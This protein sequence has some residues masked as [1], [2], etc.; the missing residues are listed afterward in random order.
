MPWPAFLHPRHWPRNGLTAAVIVAVVLG[1]PIATARLYA[2]LPVRWLAV[3]YVEF[4]RGIPVLLLLYF[5]YYGLG[6]ISVEWGLP[7]LK[8]NPYQAA[9]LGFGLNYAAYEAEIYRSALQAIPTGQLEAGRTLG[10][11]T[12]QIWARPLLT[13]NRE[14]VISDAI[15]TCG[16][17]N[18][19]ADLTPLVPA[20]SVEPAVGEFTGFDIA[21][22]S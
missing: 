9:I 15:R 12:R 10:L 16:G 5:L 3:T 22:T 20:V 13:V 1:L 8:L 2:P 19:F 11:S 17:V 7:L 14:H 18:V 21:T 6:A 4:F